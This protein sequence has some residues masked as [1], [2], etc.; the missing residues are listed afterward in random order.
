MKVLILLFLTISLFSCE[1]KKQ[2][3]LLALMN[4]GILNYDGK[5]H[6]QLIS[7]RSFTA[8][9]NDNINDLPENELDD[10]RSESFKSKYDTV[11]YL[12]DTLYISYVEC[13]NNCGTYQGDIEFHNDTLFVKVL[14]LSRIACISERIDRF[15]Y[16][17]YNPKNLHYKIS[18]KYVKM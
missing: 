16:K 13:V 1:N 10:I 15:I 11:K 4:E 3:D 8:V 6:K 12:N 9:S 18:R 2:K 7:F 17:V 5:K 14:D